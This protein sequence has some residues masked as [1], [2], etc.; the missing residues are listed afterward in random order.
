MNKYFRIIVA[1]MLL[2]A[3]S[4]FLSD[5]NVFESGKLKGKYKVDLTPFVAEAVK[6]EEGD[7]KWSEMSK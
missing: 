5:S 2:T 7:D 3:C 1:T 4:N 6:T